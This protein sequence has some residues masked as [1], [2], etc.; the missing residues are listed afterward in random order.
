MNQF[1]LILA[2]A[3]FF[4]NNLKLCIY[5]TLFSIKSKF[6]SI[7]QIFQVVLSNSCDPWKMQNFLKLE[8]TLT[9]LHRI[10]NEWTYFCY[11]YSKFVLNAY[12][13]FEGL[14]RHIFSFDKLDNKALYDSFT[15]PRLSKIV[16]TLE[17]KILVGLILTTFATKQDE[18]LL[19]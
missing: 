19:T 10:K 16:T 7:S 1:P 8:L 5:C 13:Y 17:T 15:V 12:S 2:F 18:N 11:Y 6:S 9:S 14:S 4:R 3:W